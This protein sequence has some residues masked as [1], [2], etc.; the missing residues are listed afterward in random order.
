MKR[1]SWRLVSS[2]PRHRF[3]LHGIAVGLTL[4]FLFEGPTQ[5]E[6]ANDRPFG[7]MVGLKVKYSQGEPQ[8]ALALLKELK[9]KWN[10]RRVSIAI[11]LRP[12]KIG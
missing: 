1:A 10:L 12:S 2:I 4:P 7:E 11:S 6:S 8:S 3:A 5:A 9:V